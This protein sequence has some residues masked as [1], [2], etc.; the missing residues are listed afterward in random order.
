MRARPNAYDPTRHRRCVAIEGPCCAGKT[1]LSHGLLDV[2]TDLEICHARD[3][4]DHVGGGR[5][6]PRPVPQS[7]AE[8]QAALHTLVEIEAD[9]LA[10]H[11]ARPRA[12][13]LLDRSV[14]TLLAHRH[15]IEQVTGLPCF[16][17]AARIVDSSDA[18]AWPDLVLYLDVTDQAI[19][20]RNRGKFAPDNIFID[21]R[22]NAGIRDFYTR[23]T[24]RDAARVVWLDAT[25]EIPKLV[26]T[27]ETY[28]H[29]VL[30]DHDR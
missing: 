8:D 24:D 6:L 9:R 13:L 5:F 29:Q 2:L 18:L 22:F 12:L 25:L 10:C 11:H 1:T 21:R 23:A 7:V 3:Y 15:A 4:A 30:H 16:A 17:S 26:R 14:Y 20:D 28:V 27:A 19:H